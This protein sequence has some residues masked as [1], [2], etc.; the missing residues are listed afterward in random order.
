[1]AGSPSSHPAVAACRTRHEAMRFLEAGFFN[2]DA[3]NRDASIN[4]N[5]VN[6][7]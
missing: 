2:N 4:L 7:E 3:S 1:M 6:N 5:G